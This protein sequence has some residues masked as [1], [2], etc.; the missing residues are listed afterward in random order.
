VGQVPDSG[1]TLRRHSEL[2]SDDRILDQL[3][4]TAAGQSVF[5]LARSS[6]GGSN[7]EKPFPV[8][9]VHDVGAPDPVSG[10]IVF[11]GLAG[12]RTDSFPSLSIATVPP[13]APTRPIRWC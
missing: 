2:A 12:T 8:A 7:F 6:D 11:D 1:H 4:G 9:T 3:L 13:P 10:R 5:Y